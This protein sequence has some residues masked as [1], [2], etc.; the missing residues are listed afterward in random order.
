M[1][2]SIKV[3]R[4]PYSIVKGHLMY[5]PDS[6]LVLDQEYNCLI[7]GVSSKLPTVVGKLNP[8]QVAELNTNSTKNHS[9]PWTIQALN[10]INVMWAYDKGFST[11]SASAM[12][13]MDHAALGEHP[14]PNS[15][16]DIPPM[17]A[18]EGAGNSGSVAG[19]PVSASIEHPEVK[20]VSPVTVSIPIPTTEHIH[21]AAVEAKPSQTSSQTKAQK[22]LHFTLQ[23]YSNVYPTMSYLQYLEQVKRA[24]HRNAV[25]EDGE[26]D[27]DSD[28]DVELDQ[29]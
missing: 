27:S 19:T 29:L 11:L 9:V 20:V 17:D 23:Y 24:I 2:P 4:I 1:D 10:N 8:L 6:T 5:N 15:G 18:R 28:S 16:I 14:A 3:K 13:E 25:L 21:H 22:F 7:I 26:L 12:M